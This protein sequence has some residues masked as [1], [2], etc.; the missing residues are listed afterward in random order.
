MNLPDKVFALGGAGKAIIYEFLQT[1]WIVES[2]LQPRPEPKEL[3]IIIVDTA[4]E[5][6]NRDLE[7]IRDI[8][9][10]IQK[11][12]EQLR[13]TTKGRLGDISVEYLPLTDRIQLHD[14][15]D[16][17][18]ESVVPRIASGVGM[19][20]KHWWL[21][22]E[23]INEDLDFTTGVVRR[24][25][26]GKALYYKAYAEDDD[27]RTTIDLPSSGKVAIL[28]G[29][30]G[31][32]GSGILI[33]LARDLKAT[34]RSAEITLFGVLPNDSEGQAENANA[35][36]VLSELEHLSLQ[37]ENIFK[38]R[39]L[40]PIDP[41]DFGGK[42]ANILQSSDALTEFD[43]S[44]VYLI[45]AYYN[46]MDMEDPFAHMPSFAPFIIGVPQVIRYNV[47]AIK[48]AKSSITDI[49]TAKEDAIEAE[50]DIYAEIGRFLARYHS[51]EN[52]EGELHDTDRTN[53]EN[54]L[55]NVISLLEF[56]LFE[57]LEYESA[58]I[59]QEIITNAKRESDDVIEQIEVIGG[60]I[61]AGTADV[62]Q[63]NEQYVDAIDKQLK[64]V[65]SDEL[66]NLSR[67]NNIIKQIRAVNTS[68]VEST[69]NY[70]VAI[71]EEDVN[72]GVRITGLES[73]LEEIKENRDRIQQELESSTNELE[74]RRSEQQQKVD[75]RINDWEQDVRD[76]HTE[77]I[78]CQNIPIESIAD[79]IDAALENFASEV[80]NAKTEEQLNEVNEADIRQQ[81]DELSSQVKTVNIDLTDTKRRI[82][83]SLVNLSDAKESFIIMNGEEGLI[84]RVS[85]FTTSGE[86]SREQAQKNYQMAKTK[87]DNDNVFNVS[88]VGDDLSIDVIFNSDQLVQTLRRE[89]L[90]R[91]QQIV[92]ALDEQLEDGPT[93]GIDRLERELERDAGFSELLQTAE[94]IFVDE[95]VETSDIKERKQQLE[96]KIETVEEN[97]EL[98]E[99]TLSLFEEL[100]NRREAFSNAQQQYTEHRNEHNK[101]DEMTV[102]SEPDEYHYIKSIKP[103]DVLQLRDDSDIAQSTLFETRAERQRLRGALEELA[104]NTHNPKYNGIRK[105]RI[106]SD[107]SRYGQMQIVVG[108][109]SKAIDE[110]GDEADLQSI[111][112]GAYN[113]GPGG[114]NYSSYPVEE[115]GSWD[116]GLGIF[117]GGIFL[118]N[119]R[120]EVDPDGYHTGYQAREGS[121]D[122]KILIHHAYSLEEGYYTK[123]TNVLNLEN[124][125]EAKFF[126]R[127]E[128]EI[129]SDLLTDHIETVATSTETDTASNGES[130]SE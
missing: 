35:H 112:Q 95:I 1:D 64:D 39:V 81:L 107:R 42:K 108:V 44:T 68:R 51:E 25:G 53:L 127:E 8:E 90:N 101:S 98:Y 111:F 37:S 29:L 49:L 45:A 96:S 74:S 115:G 67:R 69:L 86:K 89:R 28:A 19:D 106:S 50:A 58:S 60:S 13:D 102:A 113:L 5:E 24:R 119:I 76:I 10:D 129:N 109:L 40:I 30:G 103:N 17:I 82:N 65:I 22:P 84:E 9:T 15:N 94:E 56:D 27:I 32:T 97:V 26:L 16:L 55:N 79:S 100:N 43:R 104:R 57:E 88:N 87:L 47:D 83:S 114:D 2:I 62:N 14:Q 116:I 46:M 85:P 59:Y 4:L 11:V 66:R 52:P 18:G 6:K 75:R 63:N 3:T 110:I 92:S 73:K 125:N 117:I 31:G 54:R 122:T 23:L 128:S 21:R 41:T 20:E 120:S 36:A 71:E 118:D 121:D 93:Q 38:D 91:E 33:D 12:K 48:D 123:R 78:E 99:G 130:Q 7:R 105:R 61:R 77:L 72:P 126:L 70:L 80:S 34:Q 124:P